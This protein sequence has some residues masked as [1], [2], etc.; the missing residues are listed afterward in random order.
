MTGTTLINQDRFA[1]TKSLFYTALV[2]IVTLASTGCGGKMSS[3][4]ST[5]TQPTQP[6]TP[7]VPLGWVNVTR[8]Y[9]SYDYPSGWKLNEGTDPSKPFVNAYDPMHPETG[10]VVVQFVP[11]Y[12]NNSN[13]GDQCADAD[14]YLQEVYTNTF[15]PLVTDPNKYPR[16][17]VTW[18]YLPAIG[19]SL[20]GATGTVSISY[21]ASLGSSVNTLVELQAVPRED[22]LYFVDIWS[23]DDYATPSYSKTF[24][25]TLVLKHGSLPKGSNC[26]FLN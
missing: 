24:L 15:L 14:Q 5:G 2:A 9:V 18:L 22:G 10:Q 8:P 23:P 17:T 7:A 16:I 1:F 11:G 21:E 13:N 20:G 6:S 3:S 4:T 26:S 19:G 12:P 25:T